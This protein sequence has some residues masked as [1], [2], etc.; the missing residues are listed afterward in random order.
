MF[1]REVR[2]Q[3]LWALRER[4]DKPFLDRTLGEHYPPGSTYKLVMGAAALEEGVVTAEQSYHCPG[5]FR[6]GRRIWRCHKRSGHG[7]VNLVE[8]I[9]LSC[10]VYFYNIALSL[11]L[12]RMHQWGR[13]FGLG[14]RTYLGHEVFTEGLS[15]FY[16]FNS[17]QTGFIPNS[18]WVREIGHTSV[19]GETIN[20]GIGQ[21][22]NLMT[23]TQMARM[24]AATLNGGNFYQPQLVKNIREG[25]G[26]L[27]QEYEAVFENQ[28]NLKPETV[29]V[30]RQ[31][32]YAVVNE[33]E[34]TALGS[35]IREFNWGGKTGT[36]QVVA[37]SARP[38]DDDDIPMELNHHALFVGVAPLENPRIV[39]AVLVEHGKSGSRAAAPIA[40]AMVRNYLQR[41]VSLR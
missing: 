16:R 8:A 4:A 39:I 12:D 7:S 9:K 28:V 24:T 36:S 33:P 19:E 31:G 26:E 37:L 14:R 34:G 20:A 2:S 27:I 15:Q 25:S 38:E 21:G 35:R 6:F 3:D 40:R 41:E 30:L 1:T 22:G 32:L 13:Q 18:N 29:E 10:D 5:F 17:E 23:V 11:G